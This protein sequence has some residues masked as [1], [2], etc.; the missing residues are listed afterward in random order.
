MIRIW[1]VFSADCEKCELLEVVAAQSKNGGKYFISS[2]LL[3]QYWKGVSIHIRC[4]AKQPGKSLEMILSPA[5]HNGQFKNC[6]S[7]CFACSE[8]FTADS[9]AVKKFNFPKTCSK[10][11]WIFSSAQYNYISRCIVRKKKAEK[12]QKWNFKLAFCFDE[13]WK[14]ITVRHGRHRFLRFQGT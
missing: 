6:H 1:K 3:F 4:I 2:K 14:I 9:A 12:V 7:A 8:A 10:Q 5:N 13:I 11:C